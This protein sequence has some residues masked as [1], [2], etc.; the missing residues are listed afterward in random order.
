MR[1]V[2]TFATVKSGK[3]SDSFEADVPG[4]VNNMDSDKN[5]RMG[6]NVS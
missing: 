4:I 6:V 5:S 3:A 1:R 2:T